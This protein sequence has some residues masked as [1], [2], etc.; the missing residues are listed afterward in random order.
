MD[1]MDDIQPPK[2]HKANQ[3]AFFS[4]W[5]GA[6]FIAQHEVSRPH[7]GWR[8]MIEQ[9]K[10]VR[11]FR[12]KWPWLGVWS[13]DKTLPHHFSTSASL[14]STSNATRNLEI[15]SF[16]FFCCFVTNYGRDGPSRNT[17]FSYLIMC[18]RSNTTAKYSVSIHHNYEWNI[19]KRKKLHC[20]CEASTL[21]LLLYV[22][23]CVYERA[24]QGLRSTRCNVLAYRHTHTYSDETFKVENKYVVGH[25]PCSLAQTI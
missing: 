2:R 9:G 15:L 1:F 12:S 16:F 14:A 13:G 8:D 11:V 6:N 17:H 23:L 24:A 22:F 18:V 10:M 20:V 25:Q 3:F 21:L 19:E 7:G 4:P 5:V